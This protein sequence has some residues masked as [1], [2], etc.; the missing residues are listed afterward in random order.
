MKQ[1]TL[2]FKGQACVFIY[3]NHN[4]ALPSIKTSS[5][6][7]IFVG[8]T[9]LDAIEQDG[10]DILPEMVEA[11]CG[12]RLLPITLGYMHQTDEWLIEVLDE[13]YMELP[14]TVEIPEDVESPTLIRYVTPGIV[15]G[16]DFNHTQALTCCWEKGD[17]M[18]EVDVPTHLDETALRTLLQHTGYPDC[19]DHLY[20]PVID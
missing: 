7:S 14:V 4:G 8:F 16:Q 10:R 9:Q 19:I 2:T 20:K 11:Y 1:V 3:G 13:K 17:E 6:G 12:Q 15:L 5:C 18:Q